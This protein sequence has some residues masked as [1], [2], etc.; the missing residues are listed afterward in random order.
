MIGNT[1]KIKSR[2]G[3]GQGERERTKGE[4]HQSRRQDYW[5]GA[6]NKRD[7]LIMLRQFW[8]QMLWSFLIWSSNDAEL[9]L[10]Y[11]TDNLIL[12]PS[13]LVFEIGLSGMMILAFCGF[14]LESCF[15]SLSKDSHEEC[16][17]CVQC[18]GEGSTKGA[19]YH[20]TH[21]LTQTLWEKDLARK[22]HQTF[23]ELTE[24]RLQKQIFSRWF[25]IVLWRCLCG[26]EDTTDR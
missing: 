14:I 19:R 21:S 11:L 10:L 17:V 25:D 4:K 15:L 6:V 26:G 2:T 23:K 8:G 13:S 18:L 12:D 16:Q 9:L 7:P 22:M 3:D 5:C 24:W 20:P 1:W